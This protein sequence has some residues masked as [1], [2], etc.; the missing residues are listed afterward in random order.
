MQFLQPAAAN[1][2]SVGK[3]VLKK[4]LPDLSAFCGHA[5]MPGGLFSGVAQDDF[6]V[7]DIVSQ[8]FYRLCVPVWEKRAAEDASPPPKGYL[9][10]KQ[11]LKACQS[12]ASSTRT[13]AGNTSPT[14]QNAS[15]AGYAPLS[16]PAAFSAYAKPRSPSRCIE[17]ANENTKRHPAGKRSRRGAFLC[18]LSSST[19][20][21]KFAMNCTNVLSGGEVVN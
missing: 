2:P 12:R 19:A 16:V 4:P 21:A 5:W 1:I 7:P 11:C 3:R 10:C 9:N 20:A 8:G 18:A 6:A 14:R 17:A 13:E 15:A